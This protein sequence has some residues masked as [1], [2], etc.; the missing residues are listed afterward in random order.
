MTAWTRVV[1][2]CALAAALSFG[3]CVSNPTPHPGTGGQ[4]SDGADTAAPPDDKG[5]DRDDDGVP[6]CEQNGGFWLDGACNGQTGTVGDATTVPGG[7]DALDGAEDAD[8]NATDASGDVGP[9]PD[10]YADV[11]AD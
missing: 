6:D 7:G 1:A 3:G 8:D 2:T 10:G 4:L 11:G 9:E 5:P